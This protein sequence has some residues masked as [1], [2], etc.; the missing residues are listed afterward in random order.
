MSAGLQVGFLV[1]NLFYFVGCLLINRIIRLDLKNLIQPG[2]APFYM[3]SIPFPFLLPRCYS[4]IEQEN[5]LKKSKALVNPKNRIIILLSYYLPQYSLAGLGD[6]RNPWKGSPIQM[7]ILWSVNLGITAL[8]SLFSS[9]L[10]SGMCAHWVVAE[11]S[12][13]RHRN[14]R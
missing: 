3:P 12:A 5:A 6:G 11:G 10:P 8:Y 4:S 14:F 1:R 13:F 7:R 9:S 2:E